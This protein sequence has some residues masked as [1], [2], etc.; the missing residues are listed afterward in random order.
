MLSKGGVRVQVPGRARDVDGLQRCKLGK[1]CSRQTGFSCTEATT[2]RA[3]AKSIIALLSVESE[4]CAFVK[5]RARAMEFQSLVRNQGQSFSTVAC[6][7]A[8]AVSGGRDSDTW[9]AILC[10]S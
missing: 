6:S 10:R 1:Q 5:A 4:L 3:G 7:D 8:S 9:I 2:S